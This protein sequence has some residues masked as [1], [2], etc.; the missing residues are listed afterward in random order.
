V[1]RVSARHDPTSHTQPRS[2]RYEFAEDE[3]IAIRPWLPTKPHGVPRVDKRRIL[4]GI[5]WVLHSGA[6]WR[7]VARSFGSYTPVFAGERLESETRSWLALTI[8]RNAAV[9]I[10][11]TFIVWVH[12]HGVCIAGNR[13][14]GGG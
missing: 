8:A 4:N 9:Q 13:A 11:E 12:Q 5:V 3:W 1:L 7:D 14:G 10:I 2:L 6:S